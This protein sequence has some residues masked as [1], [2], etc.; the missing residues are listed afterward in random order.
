MAH[1]RILMV[2]AELAPFAKAGGLA[3]MVA[4]LGRALVRQGHDVRILLPRYRI[5]SFPTVTLAVTAAPFTSPV[6]LGG[7][8]PPVSL[9]AIPTPTDEPR[10]YAV[11]AAGLVTPGTIYGGGDD[12][13]RRFA[14]LAHAVMP[15]CTAIAFAPDVIHCH[16]WHT[17]L[18]PLLLRGPGGSRLRAQGA[19]TLLTLHNIGYQGVFAARLTE[20]LGL[21]ACAELLP[22]ADRA[23]NQV[24][25]LRT[26]IV[27][28]DALSTV[29]PT[30]A[31]ELLTP[32]YGHGLDDELR[33][34]RAVLTGILNGVD[35]A[36]WDP[37]TDALLPAR[38][39]ATNLAGKARCREA[40]VRIAG[41]QAGGV[42]LVGCVSRLA[43][44][45]GLHLLLQAL[46]PLLDA[47]RVA[48]VLLGT[49][50]PAL[51]TDFSVLAAR[52]PGRFAFIDRHDEALAHLVYAGA[53]AFTVPSLYEPCGLS[54]LY[55]MRY[56]A[57]PVVRATGGLRDTVTHFDPATGEGT[58]S[59]FRDADPAG[60]A[61]G[62]GEM[63]R[64]F[65][66]PVAWRRV[67]AN[68]MAA[69]F[70]WDRQVPRYEALY[71][72]LR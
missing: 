12:E 61:W 42:P 29:S 31:A 67:Q 46:P 13:A 39:S 47:G 25:F 32:E 24:N 43:T 33:S 17:A 49:G 72:S 51:E 56:G 64:W 23:A 34:R 36:A 69:D 1:L 9:L 3:D 66:D 2:T 38:Y 6:R 40:L 44:Q 57:V 52:H 5:A 60:L 53:D 18:T 10:L 68:A 58:G 54:Q 19:R 65:A 35:Y 22:D 50:D 14:L 26:G 30:H 70:S 21:A 4:G 55:A 48:A 11:D 7:T 8:H 59:V 37:A 28:A 16:D 41:L 63:L 45:K 20:D 62:L 71:R 15:L 27:T